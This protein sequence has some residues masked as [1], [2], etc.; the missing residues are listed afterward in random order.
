MSCSS[1]CST[2][3]SRLL[4]RPAFQGVVVLLALLVC[5]RMRPWRLFV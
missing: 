4:M 1:T 2:R 3:H 5:R